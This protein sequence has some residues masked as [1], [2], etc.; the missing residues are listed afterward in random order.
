MKFVCEKSA[1]LKEIAIAQEIV[2]SKQM[3]SILSNIY[4][5]AGDDTL[6]VKA[7]DVKVNFQTKLPVSVSEAGSA[8]VVGDA[9][10]GILGK[11][12][13]GEFEF[14]VDGANVVVRSLVKRVRNTLKSNS[15]D[16]FPPFPSDAEEK[17]FEVAAK[18]LRDMISKTIFAVSDD[19]TRYFMNGIF[20][21]KVEGNL[22]MVTTDGRRLAKSEKAIGDEAPDFEGVIIPVK[23]MGVL[24]K[25]LG[26]EGVVSMAVSQ[27]S[28]FFRFG[29][30]ELSSQLI[31]GSF[32]NYRRVIPENQEHSLVMNRVELVQALDRVSVLVD[33]KIRRIYL[34]IKGSVLSIS[35]E[36]NETGETEE[37]ID[38]QYDGENDVRIA[39]N[40]RYLEEP[41]KNMDADEVGIYF[42]DPG[43]AVTLKP[44]PESDFFDII[45]PMQE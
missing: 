4:L 44:V 42:T 24:L 19:Q 2:A 36:E 23:V 17:F 11:L 33:K 25:H 29:S 39:L 43:K 13:E 14:S 22:I 34:D 16:K 32:P 26:Q 41:C 3:L 37:Q 21:E 30:Y 38:C 15:T 10:Y 45:M 40:H 9:F 8:T 31:E 5:E 7:T 1:L 35:G 27:S 18:D 20:L 12:P 28:V 6:T